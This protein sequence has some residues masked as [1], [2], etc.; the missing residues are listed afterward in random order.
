[1]T[2]S[3]AIAAASEYFDSGAFLADLTRRVAYPTESGLPERRQDMRAYL[4]QEIVSGGGTAGRRR[5]DS[6]QSR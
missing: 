3:A 2:R 6:G 1:M 4:E 5:P